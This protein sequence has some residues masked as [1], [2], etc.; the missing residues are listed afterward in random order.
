MGGGISSKSV[1]RPPDEFREG[2]REGF[3]TDGFDVGDGRELDTE[4][5]RANSALWALCCLFR[6]SKR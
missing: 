6:T 1:P 3:A 4:A 2:P 5:L